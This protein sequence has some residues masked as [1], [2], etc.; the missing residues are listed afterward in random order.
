MLGPKLRLSQWQIASEST[1]ALAEGEAWLQGR[2]DI[3]LPH[4]PDLLHNRLHDTAYYNGKVYNVFPPLMTILTVLLSPLHHLIEAPEGYWL[5]WPYT[6]LAF[7]PLP[8]IGF[9]V[10]RRQVHSAAW[11]GLLTLAWMGGT[12]VLPNLHFA[13]TGLLGQV[14]HVVSQT[15]LLIFTADLLGRRRIWPALI[16]LAI[17]TWTRQLT[18]LYGLPLLWLAWSQGRRRFVT[19]IVGL[20]IIA[21]PLLT[22]NW[23]K[24]G[25]PLEFGYRYI[26]A[27][28]DTDDLAQ[29]CLKYG[30][31]SPH[32][33]GEN[34]YYM[35]AAPP[36]IA[37][38]PTQIQI[39]GDN[40]Y[41]TSLWITTPLA[42][43]VFISAAAWWRDKTRRILMLGTLP[44]LFGL[45][46]YHNPGFLESGYSRFA[47]DFLPIWLLV[48]APWTR[49]GWRTWLTLLCTAWS[50]LY[51]Q[52][53]VP[54]GPVVESKPAPKIRTTRPA[55]SMPVSHGPQDQSMKNATGSS[56]GQV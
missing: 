54:D 45:L 35:F 55:A 48:V 22:L 28:R 25:N 31:F 10:F 47:L 12:A 1:A 23:L 32:F 19:G 38:S 18:L 34:A 50:L 5:P 16:G 52:A 9:I 13:Q 20:A 43:F 24:F 2:L 51:F 39:T 4:T 42:L 30:V 7:W 41:G 40:Q 15:G 8:I 36:Y 33:V 14:D 44:V 46:C 6:L 49:N 27:G 3:P 53:V 21:A 17:A 37:V 29:R 11:A 56:H 26:Y